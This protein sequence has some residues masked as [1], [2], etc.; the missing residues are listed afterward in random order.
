MRTKKPSWKKSTAF[1]L[2]FTCVVVVHH[3]HSQLLL[4]RQQLRK[5]LLVPESV[6]ILDETVIDGRY[7]ATYRTHTAAGIYS[8]EQVFRSAEHND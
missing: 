8:L 6:R 3:R 2:I 5:T 1:L 7:V 4:G